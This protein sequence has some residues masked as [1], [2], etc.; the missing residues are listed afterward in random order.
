[1]YHLQGRKEDCSDVLGVYPLFPDNTCRFLVFDFDNHDKGAYKNDDANSDDLWKSEVDALR[2]ICE[3][4]NIDILVERSRSGRGAHLWIF[5]KG[6]VQA[7]LAR[8]FGY[9]S[10]HEIIHF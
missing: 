6:A 9:S 4:N 8:A 1:M 10:L 7:S 3:I 2:R 5:F